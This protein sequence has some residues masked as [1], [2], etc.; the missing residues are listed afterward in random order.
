MSSAVP[1]NLTLP[2]D[3]SS[4]RRISESLG[5]PPAALEARLAAFEKQKRTPW[6]SG[7]DEAWRRNNP[8]LIGR[9]RFKKW[10]STSSSAPNLT[11]TPPPAVVPVWSSLNLRRSGSL[12]WPNSTGWSAADP[13]T[14]AES[15]EPIPAPK[16]LHLAFSDG[17]V[18]F[19]VET[20]ERIQEPVLLAH[21]VQTPGGALF[22]TNSIEL[23]ADAS[24]FICLSNTILGDDPAW[25]S[26]QNQIKI[27]AGAKATILLI[28]RSG[29]SIKYT[30]ST[31][32]SLGQDAK[33]SIYWIDASS[34]WSV[35][36]REVLQDQPGSEA[37]LRGAYVGSEGSMIDLRTSQD[38]KAPGTTS[39]LLYKTVMFGNSKSVYQGL[40][41]VSPEARLTNAYQLNSNL[42]MSHQSRAAS[43]PKLE[44]LTDEVRCT[45]GASA[46]KPDPSAL[47]YLQSR[48]LSHDEAVRLL[49]DS[50]LAESGATIT[51]E[52]AR[53]LWNEA[54]TE[55]SSDAL[56]SW[57]EGF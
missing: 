32:A 20:G 54:L 9:D 44:I 40:I 23:Q 15:P 39:D 7:N 55:R 33:L 53:L 6:P 16:L 46:G 37:T 52:R 56:L 4:I 49:I 50:F 18:D 45:H 19:R 5:E 13:R 12:P 43:I 26:V 51:D 47:F 48:G 57:K 24:A 35:I 10:D 38:H 34:G 36:E 2:W 27:G 25:F 14:Q 41:N 1:A 31:K 21:N 11:S 29:N 30:E 22:A 28:N 3:E 42:L 8:R 17:G